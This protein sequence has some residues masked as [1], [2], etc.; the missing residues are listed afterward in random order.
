[1]KQRSCDLDTV[2]LITDN[3]SYEDNIINYL[4]ALTTQNGECREW[5]NAVSKNGYPSFAVR[6]NKK[7]KR[8][9]VHRFVCQVKEKRDLNGLLA[10]HTC[11]N[12][13]CINPKHLYGGTFSDNMRDTIASGRRFAN[14]R[15][16]RNGFSKL[17]DE[18]VIDL[19]NKF[20]TGNYTVKALAGEFN[21]SKGYAQI[22]INGTRRNNIPSHHGTGLVVAKGERK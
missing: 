20:K 8:I 19:R 13:I 16:E 21:I 11:D 4:L 10:C 5:K 12:K 22:L 17:L 2:K 18:S 1:M 14:Q 9:S 15:G 3:L 6:V 7:H